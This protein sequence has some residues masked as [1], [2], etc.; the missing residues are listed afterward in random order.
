MPVITGSLAYVAVCIGSNIFNNIAASRNNSEIQR[1]N[2]EAQVAA[3]NDNRELMW[4]LLREMQQATLKMEADKQNQR[5]GDIKS[6]INELLKM[7]A[8]Q[9]AQQNWPLRVPPIVMTN[10]TIGNLVSDNTSESIALHCIITSSDCLDFNKHVLPHIENALEVHFNKFW[11]T[12]TQHP[13]LF[14]GGSWIAD[15]PSN[16]DIQSMKVNLDK[17]P[18]LVISPHFDEEGP[19]KFQIE[20]WGLT[21]DNNT[22]QITEI[23]ITPDGI[24]DKQHFQRVYTKNIFRSS[25]NQI[26]VDV[27]KECIEDLV[28]YLECL[29]GYIADDYFLAS[30]GISPI[31]PALVS[32]GVINTDGMKYLLDESKKHYHDILLD[33]WKQTSSN[34]NNSS[35]QRLS[36]IEGASIFIDNPSREIKNTLVEICSSRG[37]KNSQISSEFFMWNDL[38]LLQKMNTLA[39]CLSDDV[40]RI[41][42]DIIRE[43]VKRKTTIYCFTIS[44]QE[45]LRYALSSL[46][47]SICDDFLRISFNKAGNNVSLFFTSSKVEIEGESYFETLIINCERFLIPEELN[48]SMKFKINVSEIDNMISRLM[49]ECNYDAFSHTISFEEVIDRCKNKYPNICSCEIIRNINPDELFNYQG[50]S[51][52]QEDCEHMILCRIYDKEGR[53][54]LLLPISS[55]NL[56]SSFENMFSG[57]NIIKVS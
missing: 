37:A 29:I 14:Y 22:N 33:S 1:L 10:Q 17:L 52:T 19:L 39:V 35:L 9:M 23:D 56:S 21:G 5:L 26:E 25:D 38:P 42:R 7:T 45:I 8:T 53:Q 31:L 57:Q 4:K 32:G 18:T 2:R 54:R 43:V 16:I 51:F 27:I 20:M 50:Y 13:V 6:Q 3:A 55:S 44:L 47:H 24:D 40:N 28:P 15:E 46:S 41:V 49:F 34:D 36:L 12:N 11:A 30:S 48:S